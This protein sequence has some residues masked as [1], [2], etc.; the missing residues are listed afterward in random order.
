M[1]DEDAGNCKERGSIVRKLTGGVVWLEGDGCGESGWGSGLDS[2]NDDMITC[3]MN[4][5]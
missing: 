5:R 4:T 1:G 2:Q 3:R